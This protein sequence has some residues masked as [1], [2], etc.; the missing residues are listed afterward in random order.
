[1][2]NNNDFKTMIK[3]NLKKINGFDELCGPPRKNF[4]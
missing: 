4:K 3:E 2:I 1:M